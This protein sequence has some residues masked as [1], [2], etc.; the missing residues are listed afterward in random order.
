MSY[1]CD[2]VQ[3]SHSQWA[4]F[5]LGCSGPA[6]CTKW[7]AVFRRTQIAREKT[8]FYYDVG[9]RMRVMRRIKGYNR[10]EV[11]RQL[12]VAD[13]IYGEWE[14]GDQQIP[15]FWICKIAWVLECGPE[16]LI[17]P[18]SV[19]TPLPSSPSPRI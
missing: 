4:C 17:P 6:S 1:L 14:R 9:H 16:M 2:A 7:K 11:S 8:P 19:P 13:R 12:G 5:K 18:P 3:N 15:L 10:C